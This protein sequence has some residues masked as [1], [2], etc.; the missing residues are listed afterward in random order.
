MEVPCSQATKAPVSHVHLSSPL[1][2]LQPGDGLRIIQALRKVDVGTLKWCNLR[3]QAIAM[4]Q[5]LGGAEISGTSISPAIFSLAFLR[6]VIH[7]PLLITCW[8]VCAEPLR[9]RKTL[10]PEGNATFTLAPLNGMFSRCA[11]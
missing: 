4:G 9:W 1:Y 5:S 2:F 10:F 11:E 7:L 6:A 8:S 3:P